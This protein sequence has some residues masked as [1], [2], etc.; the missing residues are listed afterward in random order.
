VE[1]NFKCIQNFGWK[2]WRKKEHLKNICIADTIILKWILRIGWEGVD[3]IQ[4]ADDTN[5]SLYTQ[6]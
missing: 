2:A 5:H 4:L 1:T 3:W 6:W